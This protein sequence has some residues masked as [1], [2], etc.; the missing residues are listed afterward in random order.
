[1]PIALPLLLAAAL[2]AD[3]ASAT[4][5]GFFRYPALRGDVLVF[6]AEGDLWSVSAAGGAPRA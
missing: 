2:S 3:A 6:A 1:M 4:R 5:P